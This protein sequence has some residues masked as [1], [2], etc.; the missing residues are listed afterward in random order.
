MM[1][2][3]HLRAGRCVLVSAFALEWEEWMLSQLSLH[4]A[5]PL[6]FSVRKICFIIY[7]FIQSLPVQHLCCSPARGVKLWCRKTLAKAPKGAKIT[8][9]NRTRAS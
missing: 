5:T 3:Y 7:L 6:C 2:M 8:D 9:I 4:R 1:R